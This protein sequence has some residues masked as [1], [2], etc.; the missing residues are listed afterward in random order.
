MEQ[1]QATRYLSALYVQYLTDFTVYLLHKFQLSVEDMTI[2]CLIAAES[3]RP[4]IEDAHLRLEFGFEDKVLPSDYRPP[5]T[6]KFIY[7][8]LRMN[9]ET[10]RR[11]LKKLVE[12]GFIMKVGRGY[13]FPAQASEHDFTEELRRF[14]V[15]KMATIA[16]HVDQFKNLQKGG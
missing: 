5:V 15:N 7:S 14:V 1:V 2:V 3:T 9:R 16:R 8:S 10:V 4:L 13:V 6:L 11:K 12:L